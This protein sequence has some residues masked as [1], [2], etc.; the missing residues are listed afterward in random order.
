MNLQEIHEAIASDVAFKSYVEG[1]GEG[2]ENGMALD[3]IVQ[4]IELDGASLTDLELLELI[5][6][7]SDLHRSYLG[8][9]IAEE[10]TG[11]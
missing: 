4:A 9:R 5:R 11:K 10:W 3:L 8:K 7:V 1:A 2:G 6:D